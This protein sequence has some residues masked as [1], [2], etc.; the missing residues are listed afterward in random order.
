MNKYLQIFATSFKQESKTIANTLISAGSFIVIMFIFY[1]LWGYIYGESGSGQLIS[2]YSLQMMIW[3]LVGTELVMYVVNSRRVT[4]QFS[5]DI[6]SGRLAYQLNKPY[7]YFFYMVFSTMGQ[8][9][10]KFIFLLPITMLFGIILVGL[11]SYNLA[12][13]ILI[14][15]SIFLAIFTISLIYG[16]IG[17][18]AFWVEE[19]TPFTWIVNKFFMIL[20]MFFPPE[21]FPSW[22]QP[23][24]IY[25]PVYATLSGPC[26][27]L[28]D[29]SWNNFLNVS[30]SQIAWGGFFVLLGILLFNKGTKKVNIN[31]G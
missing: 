15:F 25:S 30:L 4:N 29:F 27:L 26:K 10:F 6:K 19:A 28:A 31:G 9:T 13:L 11:P 16:V 12:Y 17:L 20:G 23:A 14:F 1:Q 18:L 5:A 7:N 8:V 22:L 2:G 3:Y 24:I 21:L